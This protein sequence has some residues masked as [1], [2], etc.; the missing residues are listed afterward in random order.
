[1]ADVVG[2]AAPQRFNHV[3]QS[4]AADCLALVSFAGAGACCPL[5]NAQRAPFH[6]DSIRV[7]SAPLVHVR[8]DPDV[9]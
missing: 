7:D 9:T 8:R 1:M 6:S 2:R 4:L 5:S 3:A